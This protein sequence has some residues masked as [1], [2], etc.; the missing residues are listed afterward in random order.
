MKNA[1]SV[2]INLP[3]FPA[4]L[5]MGG[6]GSKAGCTWTAKCLVLMRPVAGFQTTGLEMKWL[7]WSLSGSDRC[8]QVQE[9]NYLVSYFWL[10][11]MISC[12]WTVMIIN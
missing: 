11:L 2:S 1:F 10:A 3:A 7:A 6:Y 12:T 8:G 4:M 9:S 5:S